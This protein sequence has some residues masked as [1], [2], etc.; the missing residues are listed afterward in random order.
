MKKYF[1]ILLSKAGELTALSKLSENV[2]NEVSPILQVLPDTTESITTFAANWDFPNNEI[3]L[4]F[5][6]FGNNISP[7][8]RFISDLVNLNINVVPV[9]HHGV[10]DQFIILIQRLFLDGEIE[11]VCFRFS[12]GSGGFINFNT[13]LVEML[14]SL[15]ISESQVSILLDFGLVDEN[16]YNNYAA[17][18]IN[19]ITAI[20]NSTDF[21][22]L[23]IASG[24]F[25]ENLG[26]LN[27]PGQVY[28]LP[29]YEWYIWN[30]VVEK[31]KLENIKYSDYAIKYPYYTEANFPGSCSI[32][33]SVELEYVIYRGEIAS[34]HRD[35]NGQYITF[36][37]RLVNSNDY[38]G[39]DFSWGDQKINFYAQQNLADP[40]KKTGNATSWVEI[41]QNHHI[42][43]IT[44][45]L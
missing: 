28:R 12:N 45:I 30:L 20:P 36:S 27:P 16:N 25:L 11:K 17:L 38:L 3:F 5:S 35:G 26:S 42:T 7:L 6:L 41:S 2:K 15:Q 24:S 37:E 10:N 14:T 1:P 44:N 19:T 9:L 33:Y 4:D 8:R 21:N 40:K 43:L 34:N 32:K 13:M 31:L 22:N 39:E 23:I 18:A 29:R